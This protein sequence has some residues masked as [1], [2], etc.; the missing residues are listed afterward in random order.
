MPATLDTGLITGGRD[1][2]DTI[3]I[4]AGTRPVNGCDTAATVLLVTRPC[5]LALRRAIET[6]YDRAVSCSST[7]PDEPSPQPTS[8]PY[9]IAPSSP[10]CPMKWP[11]VERLT[12][13]CSPRESRGYWGERCVIS[14]RPSPPRPGDRHARLSYQRRN[15][16]HHYRARVHAGAASPQA[17]QCL[18]P[19]DFFTISAIGCAAFLLWER[20]NDHL[21]DQ[22]GA[23]VELGWNELTRSL[24]IAPGRGAKVLARLVDFHLVKQVP[25]EGWFAVRSAAPTLK[26]AQLERLAEH[27]PQLAASHDTFAAATAA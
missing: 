6:R 16:E 27:C 21:P 24:G 14:S 1:R 7:N 17:R 8:K 26:P 19:L 5:Y 13:V 4:D 2:Y 22:P 15:R 18:C 12:P 23:S 3:I 9:S 20:L 11:S 10:R 25:A